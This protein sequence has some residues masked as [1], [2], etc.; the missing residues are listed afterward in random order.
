MTT[1]QNMI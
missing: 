1:H